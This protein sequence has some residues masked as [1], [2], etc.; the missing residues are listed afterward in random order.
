MGWSEM[1]EDI[2]WEESIPLGGPSCQRDSCRQ[3]LVHPA[4]QIGADREGGP[5]IPCKQCEGAGPRNVCRTPK[6]PLSARGQDAPQGIHARGANLVKRPCDPREELGKRAVP[7]FR[8]DSRV[9]LCQY[10]NE[11]EPVHACKALQRMR[12]TVMTAALSTYRKACMAKRKQCNAQTARAANHRELIRRR[13][14]QRMR[15]TMRSK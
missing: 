8:P 5:N 6:M 7:T 10:K 14:R 3:E 9:S 4:W 15:E 1:I 12:I 2:C 13:S 11:N